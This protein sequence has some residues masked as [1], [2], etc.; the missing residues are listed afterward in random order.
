MVKTVLK[1]LL[2]MSA[3]LS[4][5]NLIVNI[6]PRA[7]KKGEYVLRKYTSVIA[8]LFVT[9]FAMTTFAPLSSAVFTHEDLTMTLFLNGSDVSTH[10]TFNNPLV[11]NLDEDVKGDFSF[12]NNGGT[13]HLNDITVELYNV[14]PVLFWHWDTKFYENQ[15]E[16]DKD[17]PAGFGTKASFTLFLSN[18]G[19]NKEALRGQTNRI[20][21]TLSFERIPDFTITVYVEF[22]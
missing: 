9:L 22:V 20:D 13:V 21:V 4:H 19:E 5:S 17:I 3:Y 6:K 11:I 10:D 18:V 14:Q 8:M 7:F 1:K 16:V 12:A 2:N 15:F